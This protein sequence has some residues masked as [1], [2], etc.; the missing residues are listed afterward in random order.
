MAKPAKALLSRLILGK[1][2]NLTS[3]GDHYADMQ[4]L[5]QGRTITGLMD[6]GASD[7]RVTRKFL[8]AFPQAT[9][10]LF[11]PH[12]TYREKLKDYAKSDNRIKPQF[13]ALSDSNGEL[14]LNLNQQTGM[15]SI[16]ETNQLSA[17]LFPE[18]ESSQ[19]PTI[20]ETT[21]ID[22]W[23]EQNGNPPFEIMK[24]DLQAAELGIEAR[25]AALGKRGL[26]QY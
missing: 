11:E 2:G 24:F 13:L 9:A 20:V 19:Q 8:R 7:G 6:A 22:S 12:P 21:T 15:T 5:L 17:E 16:F 10:Y 23:R 25:H 3:L 18:G 1:H 26:R 4:K 14:T